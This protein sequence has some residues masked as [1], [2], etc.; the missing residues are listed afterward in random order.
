MARST[1]GESVLTRT[2]RIL[3][4]FSTVSASLSVAEISRHADLPV[5]TAH[6]LVGELVA[7]GAL[8]RAPD[9]R[10]RVGYRLWEM[11]SRSSPARD[12]GRAALPYMEDLQA[13]VREHTQLGVLEGADVLYLERLSERDAG[14]NLAEIAGRLPLHA[15]SVGL[16][17]LAHGP[18]ELQERV[19]SAPLRRHT[20]YTV[21]DPER[22][23]R[24][25]AAVR[26][27]GYV[28]APRTMTEDAVGVAAPVR[29]HDDRVVA[30]LSVV[31]P[32][33]G[34]TAPRAH[35][36]ALLAAAR[37]VSRA[38]GAP[39]RG[40][41]VV[42][43]RGPTRPAPTGAGAEPGPVTPSRPRTGACAATETSH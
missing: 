13:V 4:A 2:M 39:V 35:V 6:R 1:S 24:V 26:R 27:D 19:L 34:A 10:V 37:G 30:A 8:E 38:M 23:R 41:D 36:P 16:V 11:A 32:L 12:L 28:I 25:L 40:G 15:T 17:L 5:A 9:K 31:V 43:T 7:L 18:P 3:G 22:L 21:T 33:R 29:D 42:H 20:P 14:R